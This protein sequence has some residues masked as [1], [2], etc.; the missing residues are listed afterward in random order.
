MKHVLTMSSFT[1]YFRKISTITCFLLFFLKDGLLKR[2]FNLSISRAISNCLYII[3]NVWGTSVRHAREAS[4][5]V[6]GAKRFNL[7]PRDIRDINTGTVA[8]FKGRLDAWLENIPDQPTTAGRQR[9][10]P[11]NSLIDHDQSAYSS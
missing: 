6:H 2:K 10:S 8:M 9:A 7:V 5:T 3:F 11:T 4:L 1:D